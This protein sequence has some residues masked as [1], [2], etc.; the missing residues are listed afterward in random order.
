LLGAYNCLELARRNGARLVFLSTSRIYPFELINSLTLEERPTR[1]ALSALQTVPGASADGISERF[2]LDGPRTLYGS[3]KLAAE[4]LIAEYQSAFGLQAVTDRCG[5]I[6]GPWQMGKVDQGV[7]SFWMLHHYFG[8]PLNYIGHGGAG[9]QVRDLLHVDDLI[10]LIDRQLMDPDRWTGVTVNVGGGVECSLSLQETTEIC[11]ELT[12]RELP[13]GSES[14][15]WH[16]DIA[17]F[18]SDCTRLYELTD[19]RPARG[20]RQV[21]EDIHRWISHHADELAVAL[22]IPPRAAAEAS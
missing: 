6:A 11:R 13:I 20:P 9:K 4:L 5:V 10:G 1:F 14:T 19:W 15:G 7:F 2:P 16:G 17:V 22:Q 8:L 18:V 12:G 21:M 3:T